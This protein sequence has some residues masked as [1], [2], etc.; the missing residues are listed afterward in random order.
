[1]T[2][3]RLKTTGMHCGSCAKRIEMEVEELPGVASVKAD[4][5]EGTTDVVFDPAQT[6]VAAIIGAIKTAGYDAQP[7]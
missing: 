7:E 6:D 3:V 1:M 4:A 5:A 2:S